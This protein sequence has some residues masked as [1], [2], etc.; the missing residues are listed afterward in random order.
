MKNKLKAFFKPKPKGLEP[1]IDMLQ[2]LVEYPIQCRKH[3]RYC[4]NSRS[5]RKPSPEIQEAQAKASSAA[6]EADWEF[7]TLGL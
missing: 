5:R 7:K 1:L 2:H 3:A 4:R 6:M